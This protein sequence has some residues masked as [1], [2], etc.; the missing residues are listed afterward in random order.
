MQTAHFFNYI[1]GQYRGHPT[2]CMGINMSG[3]M[4]CTKRSDVPYR[5]TDSDIDIY[6]IEEMAYYLYNNAYFVDDSFFKQDLI[7]Y[8]EK[9]LGI[10][11]IAQRLKFAMG[12]KTDFSDLVMIIVAGSSYYNEK[13]LRTF[14]KE[15]KKIGSKSMLERMKTRAVMLY[16][17]GKLFSAAQVYENILSNHTYKKQENE[18]YA[19][20]HLGLGKIKCRMF[21]FDDAIKELNLAYELN[22][23]TEILKTLI[24]AKLM[25]EKNN[26]CEADFDMENEIDKELVM[27]CQEEFKDMT[28]QISISPEY[29]RLAKIFTYDGRHN[30]D[31]YY[32]NIQMVL[33][34]WK[35]DYRN[36]IG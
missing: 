12:Q 34:E 23:S 4:L 21:Y 5:I 6:S 31:D 26:G 7:D 18:F 20:I 36:N 24:Y 10:K 17:N 8:I 3:L 32:E 1:F 35:E 27:R 2:I 9:Q 19:D 25:G 22:H 33:D 16:E 11:K 15:L 30:L 29:E 14:E 13:E 28:E